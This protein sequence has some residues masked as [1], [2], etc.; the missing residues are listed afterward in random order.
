MAHRLRILAPSFVQVSVEGTQ[1]THDNIRGKGD[2]E[3]TVTALKYLVRERIRTFISFTAHRANFREFTQVAQLGRRLQV[4]RV[5]ADRLIPW[6]TGSAFREK[7]LTPEETHE[8]FDIMHKA[9]TRVARSWLGRTEIAMHR[10][11]QFLAAG[12]KPYQCTAGDTLIT[13]QPNGDL[14]PCRRMPISV[15]NLMETPLIDLYYESDLFLALRDRSRISDG[16]QSCSYGKVCR[17]GLK[18]LSYAI[19]GDLFKADPGCWL[20]SAQDK[21]AGLKQAY[22]L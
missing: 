5:W 18:C 19:T 9:H 13:V 21:I 2:F 22:C 16:C 17:G 7:V 20:S 11:L 15:G 3:R 6:G 1:A 14:F 8:F 12:G 4:S 10:A